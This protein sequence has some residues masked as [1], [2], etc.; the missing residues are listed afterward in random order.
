MA[1][2]WYVVHTYSGFENKIADFIME[3]AAKKGLADK[4]EQVLVPSENVVCVR[5]GTRYEAQR[6]F[7]PGY[8]LVKMEMTDVLVK[9]EMTEETWYLVNETP[10]VTG[11]LGGKK[12]TPIS[13]AEAMR[14]LNQVQEG[15]EKPR[16]AVS[17]EVG[18]QVRVVD[19][20]FASFVGTV[21][22]VDTEKERLKVLV[23]IFGRATPVDL[24]YVQ[25]KKA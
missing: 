8:V 14:I 7:L 16:S 4:V 24:D 22:E 12:P 11:F 19:G 23:S 21:E 13:E 10:K 25:V 15:L 2:R 6:K 20:P 1:A 9:M 17:Y 18:E 5:N 3:Q